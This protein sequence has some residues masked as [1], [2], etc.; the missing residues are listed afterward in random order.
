MARARP[1]LVRAA[2]ALRDADAELDVL[3][4]VSA[5]SRLCDWK[6][7]PMWRRTFS[8]VPWL[9]PRSSSPST[10]TLPSWVERS[11]PTSVSIVVL[12]EPD[13][14]VTMMISPAWISALTSNR[15]CLRKA[16]LP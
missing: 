1:L 5:P 10:L 14:P 9:A 4:R 7:K 13:G 8:S 2:V 15:I 16:P 12:P 11:A 6:M 3:G